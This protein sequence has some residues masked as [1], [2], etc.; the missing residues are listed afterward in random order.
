[1]IKIKPTNGFCPECGLLFDLMDLTESCIKTILDDK[2]NIKYSVALMRCHHCGAEF[3]I[4]EK[5]KF[6]Q[7]R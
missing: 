3:D 1:M 6:R 7:P 5:L 2:G 4:T